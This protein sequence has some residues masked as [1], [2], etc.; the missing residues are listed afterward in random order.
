MA[1]QIDRVQTRNRSNI[2][3]PNERGSALLMAV[4]VLAIL[5]VMG[6]ALLFLSQMETKMAQASVNSKRVFYMAEA[7]QEAGRATL[8]NTNAAD[9]FSDD[10]ADGIGGGAAGLNDAI[11]F[12]PANVEAVYSADGQLIGLGGF[13]DDVPLVSLT[14]FGDGWYAAFLTNDPAEGI[15]N[16]V[17]SNELVMIT[18]VGVGPNRS[19][20]VVQAIIERRELI[21]TIPPATITLLG[22]S[23]SFLCGS[24]D[25]HEYIGDDCDGSGGIPGLYVPIVGTIGSAAEE[26]AE[27]GIHYTCCPTCPIFCDPPVGGPAYESGPYEWEDTFA[28][29]TDPTEETVVASGFGAID[30]TWT[31]CWALHDLVEELRA[32]A[33]IV[34]CTP[35]VC[36]TPVPDPCPLDEAEEYDLIFIDG[37]IEFNPPSINSGTLVVTGELRLDGR[38]SWEGMLLALGAG[39]F[40]REGAGDRE[41]SGAVMVADIA[42]PDN[43]YGTADDCTGGPN[44]DGF[45]SASYELNGGGEGET[46]YCTDDIIA[47]NPPLPYK[48]V[49]FRQR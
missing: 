49:N 3:R 47:A 8:F 38:A 36:A 17:D 45:D 1:Y 25:R 42:G 22:P 28:D 9:D 44:G 5:T 37:D 21:P 24:S 13:G 16:K 27:D 2:A 10:L 43:I 18:G 34:C 41:V 23:P 6:T 14:A 33:D 39:E 4:F 32:A 31:D 48:I 40:L 46:V 20:E 11:D 19:F 7:G 15:A 29:L 30:P 26:D 12:D 35:P